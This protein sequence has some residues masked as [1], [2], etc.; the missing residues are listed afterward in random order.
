M[1]NWKSFERRILIKESMSIV[2]QCWTTKSMLEKWFLERA[3]FQKENLMRRPGEPT[4]KGDKFIWKWNNWDITEEGEILE[5]NGK[6]MIS[7]TFGSGGYVR[8]LLKEVDKFTEMSLIQAD[9]P[10]DDKSKM[11]LYV[12]CITGQTFWMTNLKAFLEYGITL[13]AKGLKQ[14][15]TNNLVNS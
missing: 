2:Y 9:I 10:T 14:E 1:N 12:G 5:A 4:K 13:H 7:F 15:E 8:V 3:D 11:E 6:D